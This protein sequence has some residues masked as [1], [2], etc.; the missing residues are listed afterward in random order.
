MLNRSRVT[1]DFMKTIARATPETGRCKK[2][3]KKMDGVSVQ[4]S[5]HEKCKARFTSECE[6][7]RRMWMRGKAERMVHLY[8]VQHVPRQQIDPT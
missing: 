8:T 3:T 2:W 7:K 5:Q 6:C 4:C 1:I